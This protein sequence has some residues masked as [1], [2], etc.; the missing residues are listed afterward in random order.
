MSQFGLVSIK[1]VPSSSP[2][3]VTDNNLSLANAP[4]SAE[5]PRPSAASSSSSFSSVPPVVATHIKSNP[6]LPAVPSSKGN[7]PPPAGPPPS[8]KDGKDTKGGKTA[9]APVVVVQPVD[10][11]IFSL[12]DAPVDVNQ[13]EGGGC[14]FA[15]GN[16][17]VGLVCGLLRLGGWRYARLLLDAMESA[18]ADLLAVMRMFPDLRQALVDLCLH[19][20]ETIYN[21]IK[22]SV[23]NNPSP[24]PHLITATTLSDCFPTEDVL[25]RITSM[26]G[27]LPTITPLL[28]FLG[29]HVS[30]SPVLI[31]RVCRLLKVYISD[32]S[33]STVVGGGVDMENVS[34]LFSSVLLPALSVQKVSNPFLASQVVCMFIC[35]Y[36]CMYI[37]MYVYIRMYI[38]VCIHVCIY[39]YMF[40]F[41]C[42]YVCIY[43]Y[44]CMYVY[45][46]VCMMYVCCMYES[47]CI[48]VCM[49]V[50]LYLFMYVLCM[51]VCIYVC[52]YVCLL[53]MFVCMYLCIY[54]CM[55][56][57]ICMY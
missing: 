33:S 11:V 39:A 26:D 56:M 44:I 36:F 19:L 28:T 54:V 50:C 2:V 6:P 30:H 31:A 10:D 18:G 49:Y 8:S 32:R 20:T 21:P 15:G 41:V 47:M 14:I 37:Y 38:Y 22:L 3:V 46:Y 23:A 1:S 52:T 35:M 7:P 57:Y 16:Q 51:Y 45:M 25:T 53:Y 9:V 34:R 24:Q 43:A 27:F 4:V 13:V 55:Y 48:Y 29:Y 42:M 40:I 17:V 12:R 5:I